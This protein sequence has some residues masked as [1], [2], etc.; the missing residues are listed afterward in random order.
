MSESKYY[1][2]SIKKNN[3]VEVFKSFEMKLLEKQHNSY[4]FKLSTLN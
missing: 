3:P 2:Y 4:L 1:L